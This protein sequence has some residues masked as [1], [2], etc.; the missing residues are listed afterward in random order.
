MK[1]Y[2]WGLVLVVAYIAL[3]P[4][5]LTLLRAFRNWRAVAKLREPDEHEGG[6]PL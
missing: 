2:T 5:T 1:W 3:M 4:I 6:L